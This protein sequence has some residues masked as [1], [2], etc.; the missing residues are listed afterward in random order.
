[1]AKKKPANFDG[2]AQYVSSWQDGYRKGTKEAFEWCIRKTMELNQGASTQDGKNATLYMINLMVK[3][4]NKRQ[5][6][7]VPKDGESAGPSSI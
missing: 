1:M 2:P 6:G 3:E 5:P 7:A 4:I